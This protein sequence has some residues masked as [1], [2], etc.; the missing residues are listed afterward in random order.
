MSFSGNGPTMLSQKFYHSKSSPY[1][2]RLTDDYSYHHHQSSSSSSSHNDMY[3]GT[4]SSSNRQYSS[5]SSSSSSK[6]YSSEAKSVQRMSSSSANGSNNKFD[7]RH[8]LNKNYYASQYEDRQR[9]ANNIDNALEPDNRSDSEDSRKSS[10][11]SPMT[12]TTRQR[13]QQRSIPHASKSSDGQK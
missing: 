4:G 9:S 11:I 6:Y 2:A 13:S 5:P 10:R 1:P 8:Q 7:L 3:R 12:G